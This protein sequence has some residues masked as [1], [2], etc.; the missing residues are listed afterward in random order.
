MNAENSESA[1]KHVDVEGERK[2]VSQKN[3]VSAG[4]QESEKNE[5][6]SEITQNPAIMNLCSNP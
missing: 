6:K 5:T 2:K 4:K 3:I 1:L